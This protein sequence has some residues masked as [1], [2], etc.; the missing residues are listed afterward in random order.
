MDRSS[1]LKLGLVLFAVVPARADAGATTATATAATAT[2]ATATAAVEPVADVDA[3]PRF[4][5][6]GVLLDA[7]TP[8]LAA[9][10]EPARL[11]VI[12][13]DETDPVRRTALERALVRVL[14]DRRREDVVTP[15]LVRARLGAQ[16]AA[17]AEG[18]ASTAAAGLAADHVVVGDVVPSAD[19]AVLA[20][21]LL[22]TE[23]GDVVAS[24]R[25]ALD[26]G[27]ARSTA[28]ARS[29][30]VACADLADVIAEAVEASGV[31]VRAHRVGIPPLQAT[32]AA[33]AARLDRFL[34]AELSDALRARGFLV[35]ERS[36]L[37]KA[38]DQLSLQELTGTE[39][40]A[41]LGALL[42]A[43]SLVLGTVAEAGDRFVVSAR[44]I[45][46]EGAAVLG[47]AKA[48]IEREGVVS[49][50]AVE[51]RT[52]AEAALRSAVAPGWGQ[53]YNG[54]GVKAA[55]F[56]VS[57]YAALAGT[58][59]FAGTAAWSS[60]R[61]TTLRPGQDGLTAVEASKTA[62]GLREQANVLW[63]A[64]AV[65]GGLTASLWTAGIAD[66][67]IAAP[68]VD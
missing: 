1:L 4:V 15:S 66:A 11:A 13:V 49:M 48:T 53:A 21:K 25:V 57:T 40:V 54:E 9:A 47:A 45:G 19:G 36:E 8:M 24:E 16:A 39:K 52:P 6:E 27:G 31:A 63:T 64:T 43:Q 30:G 58:V 44:V 5:D 68:D 23:H 65:V 41:E 50:A 51:T 33:K 28:A 37:S 10:R 22:S 14:R 35:V 46:V 60:Q 55:L 61:Y 56:G 67:L 7:L 42:G 62:A 29:V 3:L 20:L 17:Q 34:Q 18:A 26:G 2:A 32:G 38:M 12:V 59:A